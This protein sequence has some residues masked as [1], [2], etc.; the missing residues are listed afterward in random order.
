MDE[1]DYGMHSIRVF[2]HSLDQLL[3]VARKAVY[4]CCE[5]NK[6][7]ELMDWR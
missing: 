1:Y 7:K 4:V 6:W 2:G 5:V 3:A